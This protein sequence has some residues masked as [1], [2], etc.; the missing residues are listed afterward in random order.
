MI[1]K[2]PKFQKESGRFLNR[3]VAGH[4]LICMWYRVCDC[5]VDW[6]DA[7]SPVSSVTAAANVERQRPSAA[8]TDGE[9]EKRVKNRLAA[10]RCRLKRLERQQ[11]M[12]QQVQCMMGTNFYFWLNLTIFFWLRKMVVELLFYLFNLFISFSAD[13]DNTSNTNKNS[14]MSAKDRKAPEW[15]LTS[16][17][18]NT[19]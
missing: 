17:L 12:R 9:D 2:A 6:C 19:I 18:I 11:A 14:K 16:T 4:Q 8:A 5:V 1:Y 15:T 3:R 10:H 7:F 13:I